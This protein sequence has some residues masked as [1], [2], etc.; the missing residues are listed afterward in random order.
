VALVKQLAMA[1]R[2]K[3]EAMNHEALLAIRDVVRLRAK[4]LETLQRSH[5]HYVQVRPRSFEVRRLHDKL[6]DKQGHLDALLVELLC[7]LEAHGE[8]VPVA[9]LAGTMDDKENE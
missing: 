7:S 4:I 3:E 1:I 2:Q 9:T 6:L 5:D 8:L